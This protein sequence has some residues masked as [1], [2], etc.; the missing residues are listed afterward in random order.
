M[1]WRPGLRA[2]RE[3]LGRLLERIRPQRRQLDAM[4]ERLD[5]IEA[6][7][8]RFA[9]LVEAIEARQRD[10]TEM[11]TGMFVPAAWRTRSRGAS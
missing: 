6:A 4:R 9:G 3:E 11:F 8:I 7:V 2:N 1:R 10:L 5:A